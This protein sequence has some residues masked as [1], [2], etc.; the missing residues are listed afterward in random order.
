MKKFILI[1]IL[2]VGC[3][4][5]QSPKRS[6]EIQTSVDLLQPSYDNSTKFVLETPPSYFKYIPRVDRFFR[7]ALTDDTVLN[8]SKFD[9]SN[10]KPYEIRNNIVGG[11]NLRVEFYRPSIWKGGRWSKVIGYH[12]SGTIYL[13]QYYA[14]R[15]DCEIVNTLVH[16]SMHF[17]GYSHGDN[18]SEGKDNSVPYWMGDRA[19]E[20]CEQ[21]RI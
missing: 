13:N 10:A 12:S 20:L 11:F 1:S 4:A 7:L 15:N 17:F 21:G 9:F 19:Q 2:L 5:I 6:Q 8:K 16:E 3:A 18:S 14:V